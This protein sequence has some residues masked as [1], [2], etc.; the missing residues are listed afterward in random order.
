MPLDP[1]NPFIYCFPDHGVWALFTATYGS[2][3]PE[4]VIRYEVTPAPI[5]KEKLSGTSR[6][7]EWYD[8][9]PV[10]RAVY[11]VKHAYLSGYKR[12]PDVPDSLP[13]F[14]SEVNERLEDLYTPVYEPAEY[15]YEL[16]Q[17]PTTTLDRAPGPLTGGW[18]SQLPYS[19]LVDPICAASAPC[20]LPSNIVWKRVTEE[21]RTLVKSSPDV[22]ISGDYMSLGCLS[23]SRLTHE[24]HRIAAVSVVTPEYTRSSY[25]DSR[26]PTNIVCQAIHAENME[27]GER[28]FADIMARVRTA[29]SLPTRTCPRC[30][31]CGE[32][33]FNEPD[34]KPA[35][36]PEPPRK[37]RRR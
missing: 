1:S 17:L 12:R 2:R 28:A 6:S 10:V 5:R 13:E 14:V 9:Q 24:G 37:S 3:L 29:V 21:V 34:V 36:P 18:E 15:R 8:T 26:N 32:I 7:I 16:A 20:V 11:V 35:P 4:G 27:A 23:L 30:S 33:A 25:S 31:G 22:C 19:Y